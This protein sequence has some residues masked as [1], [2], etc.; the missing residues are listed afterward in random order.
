MDLVR[1]APSE[2]RRYMDVMLIQSDRAYGRALSAYNKVI[3]QRNALLKRIAEGAEKASELTYWDDEL[4]REGAT[5]LSARASALLP[6]SEW[7]A[8][9]HTRLSGERE[10]LGVAYGPRL[11]EGWDTERI[12]AADADEIA[13]ALTST[14]QSM[15][16]RDIGAGITIAGPHRDDIALTLDGEPAAS[17]AS[18]GQQRTAALALR[19]AEARFLHDRRGEQP[20]L[21]L[22][23]VL[24]ELDEQR[25]AS[26]LDAIEADQVLITS[27]DADRF[28]GPFFDAAQVW[29]VR[30]GAASRES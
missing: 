27:A 4:S 15:R 1:G 12:A 14:L 30:G 20:I 2:R 21:L 11:A 17:S 9:Q 24:S 28:A 6:L 22:D 29:R 23:D 5:L 19:L 8:A 26:V 13:A 16:Q 7:A 25:R 10:A 3:T 18:R